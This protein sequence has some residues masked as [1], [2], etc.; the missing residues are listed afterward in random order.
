MKYEQ[1]NPTSISLV[2]KKSEA[3]F[4]D[5]RS[6]QGNRFLHNDKLRIRI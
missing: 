1:H 3:S 2:Q 5:H 4:F 6:E